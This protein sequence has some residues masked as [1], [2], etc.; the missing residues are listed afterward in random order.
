VV[1][2]NND[3]ICRIVEPRLTTIDYPGLQ[4]GEVA[5]RHLIGQLKG[6]PGSHVTN[7]VILQSKLIVRASSL[8]KN[9]GKAD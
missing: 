2:F 4:I 8:K 5:A 1:G 7:R 6:N 9:D 3:I